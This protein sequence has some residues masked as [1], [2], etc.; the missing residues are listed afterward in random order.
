ML[1][2]FSF[3][4]S[5]KSYKIE[6]LVFSQN[7]R[8]SESFNQT[9]SHVNWPKRL[10]DLSD[11]NMLSSNH[12]NLK[13]SAAALSGSRNYQTL[14]HVA[15]VQNVR[16]NSLSKA[17]KISNGSGSINGYF[18]LQRGNLVHLIV[19]LEYSPQSVFYRLKEKRRFKLNETHYLDHPKFGVLV[20]VSPI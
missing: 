7:L 10:G 1:S 17:V 5:A 19:D 13:G 6:L 16:R 14:M 3:N 18:R 12:L 8:N 20:R 4:A 15:W 2:L 9:R 11:Y